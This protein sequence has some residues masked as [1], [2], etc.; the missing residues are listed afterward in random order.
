M[1]VMAEVP[2]DGFDNRQ[3]MEAEILVQKLMS[4]LGAIDRT[5]MTLSY[6]AGMSH[7][8][9]SGIVDLPIGS[10]K[11]RIHRAKLKLQKWLQVHDHPI[12]YTGSKPPEEI[13]RAG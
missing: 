10:V 11:S 2:Q 7:S 12:Q 8:E 13:H 3:A 6:A 9:I 1:Q 5:C 4:K